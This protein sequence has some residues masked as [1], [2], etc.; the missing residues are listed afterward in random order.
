MSTDPAGAADAA[1][2]SWRSVASTVGKAAKGFV[3]MDDD[4][5]GLSSMRASLESLKQG[6]SR[7][8]A[9]LSGSE[10]QPSTSEGTAPSGISAGGVTG[11]GQKLGGGLL[12]L[13]QVARDAAGKMGMDVSPVPVVRTDA[14]AHPPPPPPRS[15][16]DGSD[17]SSSSERDGLLGSSGGRAVAGVASRIAEAGKAAGQAVGDKVGGI[18]AGKDGE[19][20]VVAAARLA[21]QSKKQLKICSLSFLLGI[22]FCTL[23]TL[24]IPGL[25]LGNP[26]SFA[27]PYTLANICWIAASCFLVGPE[28]QR[29]AM[30]KPKRLASSVAYVMSMAMTLL[31]AIK[32]EGIL[33]FIFMFVQTGAMI[34]YVASYVPHCQTLVRKMGSRLAKAAVGR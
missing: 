31:F 1:A 8:Q 28:R 32:G 6:G 21:T 33:V 5:G 19:G 7:I 12:A 11:M 16:A 22:G 26:A 25:M 18:A 34:Y 17:G 13:K 4:E 23:A 2:G 14:S 10:Q 20:G 15:S 29:K 9:A 30:M 24:G 3:R 27:L